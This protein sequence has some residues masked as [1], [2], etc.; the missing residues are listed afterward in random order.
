MA[1]QN[2][3]TLAGVFTGGLALVLTASA[4]GAVVPKPPREPQREPEPEPQPQPERS[5]FAPPDV[6]EATLPS[7]VS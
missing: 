7:Y 4:F 5:P 3:R 2:G 6:D 1:D